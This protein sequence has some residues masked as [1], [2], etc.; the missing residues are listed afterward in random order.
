MH[1]FPCIL[2]AEWLQTYLKKFVSCK[3]KCVLGGYYDLH[4]NTGILDSQL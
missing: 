4:E 3:Y 1:T 2:F